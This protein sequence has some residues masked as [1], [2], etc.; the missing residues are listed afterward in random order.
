MPP[1]LY[2]ASQLLTMDDVR[3]VENARDTDHARPLPDA[4]KLPRYIELARKRAGVNEKTPDAVVRHRMPTLGELVDHL[5][6][7][8][9][10]RYRSR[11]R[12]R[13]AAPI[14]TANPSETSDRV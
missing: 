13:R 14:K 9:L 8:G 11:C 4:K 3:A 5:A 12:S 6:D 7:H 1:T 10:S 2:A